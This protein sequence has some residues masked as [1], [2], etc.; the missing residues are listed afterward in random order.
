MIIGLFPFFIKIIQLEDKFA[1]VLVAAV[2][3]STSVNLL[4]A[5]VCVCSTS[6]SWQTK[7]SPLLTDTVVHFQKYDLHD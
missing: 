1:W 6:A 3:D 5:I 4:K 7:W 2:A